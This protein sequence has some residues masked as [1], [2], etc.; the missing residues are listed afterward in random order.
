MVEY[1]LGGGEPGHFHC[2]DSFLVSGSQLWSQVASP[3][4]RQVWKS[5][6]LALYTSRSSW[7]DSTL[8]WRSCM[9]RFLGT[10]LADTFDMPKCSWITVWTLPLEIPHSEASSA[11]LIWRL[12]ST[13]LST[14]SIISWLMTSTRRPGLGSSSKESRPRLNSTDHFATVEYFGLLSPYTS[15]MRRWISLAFAPSLVRNFM[16]ALNSIFWLSIFAWV[17]FSNKK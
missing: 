7:L 12:L 4:T 11:T 9:F 13:S 5:S 3:V 16:T 1:F 15:A 8:C 17:K 6:G 10:H 14:R 2:M